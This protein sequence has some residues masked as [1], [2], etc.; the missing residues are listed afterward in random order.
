[1]DDLFGVTEIAKQILD[2]EAAHNPTDE[3]TEEKVAP[4]TEE[5]AAPGVAT[6]HTENKE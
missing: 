4:K 5:A 1:M 2:E 3:I 6:E